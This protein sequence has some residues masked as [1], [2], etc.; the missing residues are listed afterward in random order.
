MLTLATHDDCDEIIAN[1]GDFIDHLEKRIK[2]NEIYLF[3][4]EKLSLYRIRDY[5]EE[6]VF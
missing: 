3:K 1:T 2:R 4:D 5:C 6:Q